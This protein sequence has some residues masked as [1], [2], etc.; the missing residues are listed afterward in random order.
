MPTVC[1]CGCYCY[2]HNSH[3]K[4]NRVVIELGMIGNCCHSFSSED[5][6]WNERP[7]EGRDIPL[8][9]VSFNPDFPR[10]YR[11]ASRMEARQLRTPGV[12]TGKEIRLYGS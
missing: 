3:G 2:M 12:H 9:A 6:L 7:R 11:A 5:E 8:S 1:H 10:R 4:C